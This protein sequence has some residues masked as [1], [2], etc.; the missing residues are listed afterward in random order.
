M[1]RHYFGID[2]NVTHRYKR[3]K[4]IVDVF[5]LRV[6]RFDDL[7]IDIKRQKIF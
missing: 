1:P 4:K 7:L 5:E 6:L 3:G 2:L